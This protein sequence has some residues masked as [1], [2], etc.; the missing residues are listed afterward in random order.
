MFSVHTRKQTKNYLSSEFVT[1]NINIVDSSP[2]QKSKQL[3]SIIGIILKRMED[4]RLECN[5]NIIIPV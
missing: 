5:Q 2:K 3:F 4:S 1:S